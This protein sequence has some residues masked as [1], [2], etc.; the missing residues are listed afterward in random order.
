[1]SHNHTHHTELD[2]AY[3]VY[4]THLEVEYV[5]TYQDEYNPLFRQYMPLLASWYNSSN[6]PLDHTENLSFA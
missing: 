1:M 2:V 5:L 6:T 4:A 3:Q